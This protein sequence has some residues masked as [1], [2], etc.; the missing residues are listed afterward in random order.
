M[1]LYALFFLLLIILL[2]ICKYAPFE[3]GVTPH[4]IHIADGYYQEST[5]EVLGENSINISG[6]E[7]NSVWITVGSLNYDG[8]IICEGLNL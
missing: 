6:N 8:L 3:E 2:I 5:W 7:R 1:P 4:L